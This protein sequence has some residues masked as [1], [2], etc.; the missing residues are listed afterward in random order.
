MELLKGKVALITGGSRGIGKG[1]ALAMAKHGASIAFT[2]TSLSETTLS[3]EKELLNLGIKAKAYAS[4]AADFKNTEDTV[5]Q[6]VEDFGNID[7]LVNNAGITRDTL[8]M[9]MSEEQWDLVLST[10]LKSVFNYTK[11]VQ[12][13]MLKQRSGSIINMS[14][15]VGL[16]GNAGQANYAASKAGIIGFS[17][18][19]AKELGARGIRVNVVAP[20]FIATEM[21]DKLS[22][23]VKEQWISSVPLKRFGTPEDIANTCIFLASDMASYITGQTL[24]VCGGMM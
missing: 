13:L 17:Q 9:R 23:E 24:S 20:G 22:E 18:S 3:T 10:N 7:I 11:S 1:I 16:K 2:A 12:K 5:K 4:N 15:V 14:S 21:T 8:L 19:V 6:I